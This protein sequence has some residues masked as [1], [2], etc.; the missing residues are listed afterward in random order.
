MIPCEDDQCAAASQQGRRY[1]ICGGQVEAQNGRTLRFIE[2]DGRVGRVNTRAISRADQRKWVR[3]G[4][5]DECGVVCF[6][7]GGSGVHQA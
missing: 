5:C 7:E 3:A 1:G 6:T 4:P 2:Q